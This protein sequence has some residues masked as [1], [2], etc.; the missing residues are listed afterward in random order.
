MIVRATKSLYDLLIGRHRFF[1]SGCP[2]KDICPVVHCRGHEPLELEAGGTIKPTD[3]P[4]ESPNCL[5]RIADALARRF[6]QGIT[7]SKEPTA[8]CRLQSSLQFLTSRCHALE[9]SLY[10]RALSKAWLQG[11]IRA[12]A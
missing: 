11:T 4:I 8:S 10:I 5:L 9:V 1:G 2:A 7:C 6:V 3:Q 12:V